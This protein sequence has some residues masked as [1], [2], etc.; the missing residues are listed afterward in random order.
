M[1]LGET[2]HFFSELVMLMATANPIEFMMRELLLLLPSSLAQASFSV[3]PVH[4]LH[5]LHDFSGLLFAFAASAFHGYILR[6]EINIWIWTRRKLAS[7][8]STNAHEITA[9]H[10]LKWTKP[11]PYFASPTFSESTEIYLNNIHKQRP[12]DQRWKNRRQ[13]A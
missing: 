6:Q 12:K 10:S 1:E 2:F 13:T 4:F 8:V 5:F 9:W 3:V 11:A 7:F